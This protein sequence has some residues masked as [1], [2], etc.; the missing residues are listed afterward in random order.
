[1]HTYTRE[2]VRVANIFNLYFYDGR[3][4]IDEAQLETI[5]AIEIGSVFG[6]RDLNEANEKYGKILKNAII[7]R[8]GKEIYFLLEIDEKAR[9]H[10]TVSVR[11]I[12]YDALRYGYK[13]TETIRKHRDKND[14]IVLL[15][16]LIVFYGAKKWDER[17]TLSE[18]KE[19]QTLQIVDLMS[20]YKIHLIQPW[21]IQSMRREAAMMIDEYTNVEFACEEDERVNM[22]A[23]VQGMIDDAVEEALEKENTVLVENV[24]NLMKN[25]NWTAQQAVEAMGLTEEK[26]QL[27]LKKLEA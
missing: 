8:N 3:S 17:L 9:L 5:N 15:T 18:M 12:L 11:N 20:G 7:R 1:M 14:K 25:M 4:I 6:G 23:G 16:T 2:N 24:K 19:T 21:T 13:I 22:C 27:V 26:K 10:H